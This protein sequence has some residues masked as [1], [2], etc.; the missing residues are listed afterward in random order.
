MH[1]QAH[2]GGEH[3]GAQIQRSTIGMRHPVFIYFY[4]SLAGL[5]KIFYR[6]LGHAQTVA[7]ILHTSAVALGAEQLDLVVGR[8]VCLQAL[9]NL[10]CVVEHNAGR[11]QVEI[12]VRNDTGV[13]PALIGCIIHQEHM[14]GKLFAEAQLALIGRLCL[15]GSGF[16]DFDIQH[17]YFLFSLNSHSPALLKIAE[18]RSG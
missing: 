16:S 14:I 8:A 1:A 9:K 5:H 13:M 10:L 6:D 12:A 4:Q 17:S 15:G 18:S 7:G 11:I 2:I 3:E